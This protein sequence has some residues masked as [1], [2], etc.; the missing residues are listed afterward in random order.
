MSKKACDSPKYERGLIPSVTAMKEAIVVLSRAA[1]REAQASHGVAALFGEQHGLVS[2]LRTRA[3]D[4]HQIAEYLNQQ[5]EL[6]T[7]RTKRA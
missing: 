4:L 1:V 5:V 6:R 3:F 7:P 2:E